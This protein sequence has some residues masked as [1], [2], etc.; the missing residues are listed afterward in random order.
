MI[1]EV[2]LPR[3]QTYNRWSYPCIVAPLP[4]RPPF[5]AEHEILLGALLLFCGALYGGSVWSE[6]EVSPRAR[7]AVVL[8][9]VA[10]GVLFVFSLVIRIHR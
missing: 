10:A 2:H 5:P 1:G 7:Q 3:R 6:G 9:L 8:V 4:S